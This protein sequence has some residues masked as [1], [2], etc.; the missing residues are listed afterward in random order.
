MSSVY[1]APDYFLPTRIDAKTVSSLAEPFRVY[2]G[3]TSL[4][5][6]VEQYAVR[7]LDLFE[8]STPLG[9][10]EEPERKVLHNLIVGNGRPLPECKY[11]HYA[12]KFV[13]PAPPPT[14]SYATLPS[15]RSD[16]FV[17]E[18]FKFNPF[19]D[20]DIEQEFGF[21][22]Y[23]PWQPFHLTLPEGCVESDFE[24]F[25]DS[26]CP[27][28]SVYSAHGMA[29]GFESPDMAPTF[30]PKDFI[31]EFADFVAHCVMA[32]G[33]SPTWYGNRVVLNGKWACSGGIRVVVE[34]D[35]HIAVSD[36]RDGQHF[37]AGMDSV[38]VVEDSLSAG[39]DSDDEDQEDL[40]ELLD[41]FDLAKFLDMVSIDADD[42]AADGPFPFIEDA[43][44]VAGVPSAVHPTA[45]DPAVADETHVSAVDEDLVPGSSD[46]R[47]GEST[48]R[49]EADIL[50]AELAETMLAC[51]SDPAKFCDFWNLPAASS[52]QSL[53][54]SPLPPLFPYTGP[55]SF[56]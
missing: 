51:M 30:D 19:E 23:V 18:N 28:T 14:P 21:G 3:L 45:S 56:Q 39:I 42:A 43:D 1:D 35:D 12:E 25:E 40:W 44:D 22:A 26:D 50:V 54:L 17:R 37:G 47:A 24:P 16:E 53:A 10:L 5:Q 41:L 36:E 55:P 46:G 6:R 34:E 9:P 2:A 20:D 38:I 49:S 52:S 33:G 11:P 31:P 48:Q 15:W 4:L 27:F 32:R 7:Y 13:P 8:G 29:P